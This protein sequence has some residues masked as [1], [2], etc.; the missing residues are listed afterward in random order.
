MPRQ[1]ISFSEPN[2][3]WL[4]TKVQSKEFKSNSEAVNDALR[5]V[6]DL[7]SGIE[8]IRARLIKAEQSGF[9]A[10]TAEEIL[11]DIKSRARR[12]GVL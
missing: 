3:N 8:D 2:H 6:R 5:R 12:D 9:T 4:E 7:E 11:A 1:S 10:K